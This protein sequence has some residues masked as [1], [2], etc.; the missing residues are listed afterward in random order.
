MQLYFD[1]CCSIRFKN[2]LLAFFSVDS[3]DLKISHVLDY[4][5]AGTGDSTW[6]KP[7]QDDPSIIVVTGDVGRDP[8]KEKLP[9]I[10]KEMG[11][12]HIAFTAALINAGYTKQKSAIASVWQQI[13]EQIPLLPRGTKVKLGLRSLRGG[14]ERFELRVGHRSL[15]A[16]LPGQTTSDTT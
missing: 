5:D 9:L 8:S 4:Y 2:D 1:E 15:S 11:I 12:T 6:L 3:Q 16:V 7:L 13:V 10:C 14:E